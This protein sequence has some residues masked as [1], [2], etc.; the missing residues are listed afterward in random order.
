MGTKHLKFKVSDKKSLPRM[1]LHNGNTA[2]LDSLEK[3][4]PEALSRTKIN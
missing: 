2:L 4:P 3:A 1:K